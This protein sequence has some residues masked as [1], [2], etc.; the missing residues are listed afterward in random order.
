MN[1]LILENITAS[2]FAQNGINIGSVSGINIKNIRVENHGS[3]AVGA[4]IGVG[5]ILYPKK[6]SQNVI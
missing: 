5:F 1:G 4:T 6:P 3:V 2:E